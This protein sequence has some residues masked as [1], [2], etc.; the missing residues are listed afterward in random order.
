LLK[1]GHKPLQ[2]VGRAQQIGTND[3][4]VRT[5]TLLLMDSCVNPG[6]NWNAWINSLMGVGILSASL[7]RNIY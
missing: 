1:L 5:L 3:T 6:L 4:D 7:K 2:T